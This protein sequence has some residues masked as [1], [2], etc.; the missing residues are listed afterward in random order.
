[1]DTDKTTLALKN[2]DTI[3]LNL[4]HGDRFTFETE[5]GNLLIYAPEILILT[6]KAVKWYRVFKWLT[7]VITFRPTMDYKE[8]RDEPLP[9]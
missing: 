4:E 1:M 2:G 5:E 3:L 9:N 6:P 8:D 7:D